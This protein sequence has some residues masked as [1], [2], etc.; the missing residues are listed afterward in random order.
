MTFAINQK[1]EV[2]SDL[3]HS[4]YLA[5]NGYRSAASVVADD[6]LKRLFELYAQQ[7]RRFAEELREYLPPQ[8]KDSVTPKNG[9]RADNDERKPS[10]QGSLHECLEIDARNLALYREALSH[11][12][13]PTRAQLVIAAQLAL[14]ERVHDR[15]SLMANERPQTRVVARSEISA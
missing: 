11:R 9:A 15:M 4:C 8:G 7:R 12:A 5:Q 1:T 14:M 3:I 6:S 13:L 2:V 10:D